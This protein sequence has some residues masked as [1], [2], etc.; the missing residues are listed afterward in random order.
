M[1]I[2]KGESWLEAFSIYVT[3]LILSGLLAFIGKKYRE[4]FIK[5]SGIIITMF[6]ISIPI[7]SFLAGV[8]DGISGK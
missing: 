5:W 1:I 4:K 7:L 2:I 3:V 6:L 8:I